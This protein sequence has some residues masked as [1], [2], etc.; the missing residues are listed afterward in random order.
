MVVYSECITDR[1]QREGPVVV[2][3][4]CITDCLQR[5]GPVVVYSEC[6][7]DLLQRGHVHL[8]GGLHR[9]F[10]DSGGLVACAPRILWLYYQLCVLLY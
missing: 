3:P 4:E 7:I 5:E 6:I 8:R 2:Y 1:L 10:A 9:F